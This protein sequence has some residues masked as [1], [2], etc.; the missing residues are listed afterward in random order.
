ML[1]NLFGGWQPYRRMA[2][3]VWTCYRLKVLH[4][5]MDY[6]YWQHGEPPAVLGE[7]VSVLVVERW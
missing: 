5:G 4:L 6:R 7:Y 2:G 3:G 1:D